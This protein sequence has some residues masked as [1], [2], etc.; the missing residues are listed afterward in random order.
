MAVPA[1]A[2][3][4]RALRPRR[5]TDPIR[6]SSNE[7]PLGM[8]EASRRAVLDA[9]AIGNR[10]PQ[11]RDELQAAVAARH[12]VGAEVV[13]GN[14]STEVLQMVVQAMGPGA[15]L[16]LPD[17][18]FEHVEQYARPFGIDIVKVPLRPDGSHDLDGMRAAA[19][20]GD[21]SLVFVCNPNNPTGTLTSC[22]DVESWIRAADER[23]WFLVDEAYFEYVEA[24]GYRSFIA[25]ALSRPGVVVSRTFSKVYG[26]AGLRVGYALA[27]P[28]T[29]TRIEQFTLNTNINQ[30]GIAAALAA[31]E[32]PAFVGRSV[33]MNRDSRDLAVATLREL[34]IPHLPTHA[35]FLM[36]RIRSDLRG[37]IAAMAER[38][39]RVGRPFPPMLDHNRVSFGLPEEM[40]A[41]AAALRE[42]RAGG[43]V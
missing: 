40:Q 4:V 1:L 13:L 10:Y 16:V 5:H 35:N 6:L 30:L 19:R 31:L 8:P 34:E 14:G 21:A 7:N 3:D 12:G 11:R 20:G 32:E 25:L 9:L 17:P 38:G 33:Q 36:H 28:R 18:T 22:D 23:T 29:A 37:Y 39:I 41:W 26:L 42:L 24:P 27:E 15:R 2:R 43:L